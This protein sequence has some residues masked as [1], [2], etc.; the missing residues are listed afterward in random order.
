MKITVL[1]LFGFIVSGCSTVKYV[2]P[3]EG[4]TAKVR[5]SS[6]LKE[7]VVVRAYDDSGCSNEREWMR[8][9]KGFLFNSDPRILDIPLSDGIHKNAFKEFYI[10]SGEEHVFMFKGIVVSN[11]VIHSCGVPIKV[12]FESGK[13]YE[14]KLIAEI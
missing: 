12:V 5:F 9:R 13:M 14:V 3:S 10:T 1:L 11:A 6:D 4:P 7:I 8:L 2:E